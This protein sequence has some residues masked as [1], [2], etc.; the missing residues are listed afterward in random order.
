MTRIKAILFDL[1]GVLVDMCEAHYE[2]LNKALEY[3]SFP[4]IDREHHI[5]DMNG[6][7]TKIKLEKLRYSSEQ[8]NIINKTKQR[9][10]LEAINKY[11]RPDDEK[12]ELLKILQKLGYKLACVTNSIT[13]TTEAMLRTAG[14]INFFD[15]IITNEDVTNAKPD[16]EG[17]R[18][19]IS[20]LN[21]LPE[22]VIIVEDSPKGIEAA[23]ATVPEKLVIE[24][25]RVDF[26]WTNMVSLILS[27]DIQ[28]HTGYNI[29]IMNLEHV[30]CANSFYGNI[31]I[32]Y[33]NKKV[34]K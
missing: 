33:P 21:L 4:I 1:D 30:D 9:Y 31:I 2:S 16:P 32:D 26:K 20:K 13:E 10:T 12:I 18:L 22:E 3:H 11:V 8:I 27:I 15:I 25:L 14:I 5:K 6:L 34:I 24:T 29:H 23:C 19:A 7:P 17:Y 28:Y